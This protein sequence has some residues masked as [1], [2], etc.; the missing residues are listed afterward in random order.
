MNAT[1]FGNLIIRGD[2]IVNYSVDLAGRIANHSHSLQRLSSL[3]QQCR[4]PTTTTN[5]GRVNLGPNDE[6]Q[7]VF[8]R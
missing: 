5:K 4:A 1:Q 3:P 6:L 7:S 8:T 2:E